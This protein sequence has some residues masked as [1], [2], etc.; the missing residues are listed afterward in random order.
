VSGP[1]TV[2]ADGDGW[3]VSVQG[4]E[5]SVPAALG[6]MFRPAG[7]YTVHHWDGELMSAEPGGSDQPLP[8][9]APEPG[10]APWSW[11]VGLL[12]FALVTLVAPA[13][14][15]GSTEAGHDSWI[16][17]S[18]TIGPVLLALALLVRHRARRAR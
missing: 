1:A 4:Y 7:A 5:F 10:P 15:P 2:A 12:L 18:L 3:T 8:D 13:P 9:E 6:P 11:S 16:R 17:T 14:P